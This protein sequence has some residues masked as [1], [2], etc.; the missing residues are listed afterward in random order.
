LYEQRACGPQE[1][2][3]SGE[4]AG[5]QSIEA[6]HGYSAAATTTALNRALMEARSDAG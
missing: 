2:R 6:R 1:E 5:A 4:A 3:P